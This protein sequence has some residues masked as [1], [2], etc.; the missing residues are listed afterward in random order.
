MEYEESQLASFRENPKTQFLC[1]QFDDLYAKR[2]EAL[3]LAEDATMAELVREELKTLDAQ[4][5]QQYTEMARIIEASREEETKPFGIILEVRAGAGGEEAALFAEELAQMYLKYAEIQ[6]W[7]STVISESR[8]TQEGTRRLYLKS[9]EALSMM[10][11]DTRPECIEFNVY[12]LQRKWDVF[13]H[14]PHR[15]LFC[16]CVINQQSR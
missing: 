11:F 7:K 14:Q 12:R 16:L 9:L 8:A 15:L 10:R 1:G 2:E 13:I 3:A 4:L 6:G 5:E